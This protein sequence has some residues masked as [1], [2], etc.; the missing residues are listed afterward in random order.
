MELNV[1]AGRR[2]Y[3]RVLQR[4]EIN[5]ENNKINF[6]F[7]Q[8]GKRG[9]GIWLGNGDEGRVQ[10]LTTSGCITESAAPAM[11]HPNLSSNP[12]PLHLIPTD[13]TN[14]LQPQFHSGQYKCALMIN[15]CNDSIFLD[16]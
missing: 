12:L 10:I 5:W 14:I 7:K 13:R 9:R 3:P 8:K 6:H 1:L 11:M 2:K 16:T 4:L 15:S